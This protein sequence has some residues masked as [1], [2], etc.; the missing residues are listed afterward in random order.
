MKNFCGGWNHSDSTLRPSNCGGFDFGRP[1][2]TAGHATSWRTR[3]W[4]RA[5]WPFTKPSGA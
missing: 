3:L 5:A 4:V 1:I 2:Q